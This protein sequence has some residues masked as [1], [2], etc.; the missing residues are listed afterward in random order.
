VVRVPRTGCGGARL[1]VFAAWFAARGTRAA[2]VF[3]TMVAAGAGWLDAERF[4]IAGA[5]SIE[6]IHWTGALAL[7]Q[8]RP[9]QQKG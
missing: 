5:G 7:L 9:Q 3:P 1:L 2:F 8:L 6:T 4:S